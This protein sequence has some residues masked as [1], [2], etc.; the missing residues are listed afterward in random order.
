MNYKSYIFRDIKKNTAY[1]LYKKMGNR[2]KLYTTDQDHTYRPYLA[3]S[4]KDGSVWKMEINFDGDLDF[5]RRKTSLRVQR[6][7]PLCDCLNLFTL[8]N[9]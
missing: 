2:Q 1:P 4:Q 9:K 7:G 5:F 8:G 6:T 3:D